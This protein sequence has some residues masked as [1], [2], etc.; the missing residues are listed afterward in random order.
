MS[1]ISLS[2]STICNTSSFA[3][4]SVYDTFIVRL[5][6]H[7][8]NASSRQISSFCKV[9]VSLPYNATLQTSHKRNSAVYF[10]PKDKFVTLWG[11]LYYAV[12]FFLQI[13]KGVLCRVSAVTFVGLYFVYHSSSVLYILYHIA[14]H[15]LCFFFPFF[16][17]LTAFVANK[18]HKRGSLDHWGLPPHIVRVTEPVNAVGGLLRQRV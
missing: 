7:I 2:A 12:I 8:S 18:L 9:H 5:H 11:P 6:I 15:I 16:H 10:T 17:S 4:C 3:L 13:A 1:I 14:C